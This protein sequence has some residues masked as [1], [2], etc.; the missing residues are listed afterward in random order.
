MHLLVQEIDFYHIIVVNICIE[1][2]YQDKSLS[3]HNILGNCKKAF[4]QL[5]N[6]SV[7]IPQRVIETVN[8][9]V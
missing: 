5:T 1:G 2:L 7:F 4:V 8:D 9:D 6:Y 3:G